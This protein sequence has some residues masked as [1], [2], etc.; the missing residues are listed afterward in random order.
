MLLLDYDGTLVPFASTPELAAPDDELKRLLR[1]LG[2]RPGTKIHLL[3]GRTRETL[4]KWL[5]DLPIALHAEHGYWSRPEAGRSWQ[6]I[7]HISPK[8]KEEILPLLKRFTDET[9][10]AL[11]EEK[12]A[13]LAWHYRLADP[14]LGS[15]QAKRLMQK[16]EA[17]HSQLPIEI[18]PGSKVV[19]V[20]MKGVNKGLVATRLLAGCEKSCTVIAMGDDRTDE[21]MFAALPEDKITVRIGQGPSRA[22]YRLSDTSVAR[23]LLERLLEMG[24]EAESRTESALVKKRA[25]Q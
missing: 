14:A 8:W 20:R 12:T 21:D 15:Q 25:Q 17:E 6:A 1:S 5:S 3:S 18:L 2:E 16:L 13:G 11:I 19:E 4:D 9:P 10:G 23:L 7:N 24:A 22:R